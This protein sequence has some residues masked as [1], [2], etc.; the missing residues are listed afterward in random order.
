MRAVPSKLTIS[1]GSKILRPC[2]RGIVQGYSG[3]RGLC[4]KIG[5]PSFG[6]TWVS[7]RSLSVERHPAIST[8]RL[9]DRLLYCNTAPSHDGTTSP[10]SIKDKD[11][12][13]RN[14]PSSATAKPS[15]RTTLIAATSTRLRSGTRPSCTSKRSY[16]PRTTWS[17][18]ERSSP[19]KRSADCAVA[20]TLRQGVRVLERWPPRAR[21]ADRNEKP[22][23]TGFVA[24]AKSGVGEI[25]RDR[26]PCQRIAA[27]A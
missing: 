15:T 17:V 8:P 7:R 9:A 24:E 18:Q 23:P 14:S 20:N 1:G 5:K 13:R 19:P 27:V 12:L 22:R 2:N 3:P 26:L 21:R 6:L 16:T 10:M 11:S 25:L 4:E